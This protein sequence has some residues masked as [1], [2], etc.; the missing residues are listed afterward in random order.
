MV[1]G[2][3][4]LL[5]GAE[6]GEQEL[7]YEAAAEKCIGKGGKLFEPKSEQAINDQVFS[8]ALKALNINNEAS[9]GFW[10]G[11]IDPDGSGR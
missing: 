11:V 9:K 1:S 5:L 10:I 7:S 2:K 8:A 6:S 4:F 3:C